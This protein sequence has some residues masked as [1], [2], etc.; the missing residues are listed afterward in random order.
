MAVLI[1]D[2]PKDCPHGERWVFDRFQRDLDDDWVVLHSLGLVEHERKLW[3]E[4]DF[5]V[6][7][8]KGIFVIEVKGGKVSCR[9]GVWI[10]ANPGR[11]P[12]TRK[13]SPWAQASSAMFALRKHL[14]KVAPET[15]GLLFGYGVVMPHEIF[16]TEGP[17]IDTA[18]LLD[19]SEF[20]RNLRFYIGDL[21]RHWQAAHLKSHGRAQRL[22]TSEQI[23]KIRQLLRPDVESAFS[24]GSWFTGL[25][26]ELLQLTNAQ[27]KAA[28]GVANNPRTVV[29]G[30]AGTGKTIIAIDRASR[31]AEAG[32]SVLYLCFNQLLSRHVNEALRGEPA[33]NRIRV[34]HIHSLFRGV[35]DQ[36]RLGDQLRE[37]HGNNIDLFGRI[38]PQ[39]FV[40]A[41]LTAGVEPVDVLVIDEAQDVMTESNLDALDL[42][43]RDGLRRGRWHMFLDPMQNIYGRD[44]EV[45]AARLREAGFASYEL[46]ENCRNTS[47]VASQTS[48]ISGI[49]MVHDG[50]IDGPSCDCVFFRDIDDFRAKLDKEVSLLR[51]AGLDGK[52]MII[53]S[54]RKRDNS[55]LAG[56]EIIGGLPVIDL[57]MDNGAGKGIYYATMQA[58]KG[59]E[60]RV[61]L[62]ID[63]DWIG[64]ENF[65]MLHYA[66]LSRARGLLRPFIADSDRR[67]YEAQAVLYGERIGK[68]DLH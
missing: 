24:L 2:T 23:R 18:V 57:A 17:E 30:R 67:R 32:N 61:V 46:V 49:D 65:S 51:A 66:G 31:L 8:T 5:V 41:V 19:R 53:L 62:A 52:D 38:Y 20:G 50:T 39:I 54:T 43:L 25:E 7:S 3:G 59:L 60:R 40:D 42:L 26:R 1:P 16:S 55:L 35:I 37:A 14:K 63:V 34:R 29:S 13:E 33:A 15:E 28:R 36:A 48:I 44:S 11:E 6:L 45:A 4:I 56:V 9:N 12:Y 10:Y 68:R 22:P 64:D 27:I 47:Q 21:M 58:F